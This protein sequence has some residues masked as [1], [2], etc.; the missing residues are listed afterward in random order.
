MLMQ[1]LCD[2]AIKNSCSRVEWTTD[3][4][5]PEAQQFYAELGI[6]ARGSKIF[7][8]AE[9]DELARLANP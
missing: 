4:D 5:N 9:G 2:I 6:P 3:S 8:R 7:Y 1:G